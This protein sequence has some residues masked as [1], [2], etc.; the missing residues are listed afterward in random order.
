MNVWKNT[1]FHGF[2]IFRK[3]ILHSYIRNNCCVENLIRNKNIKMY[4]TIF[5]IKYLKP[6]YY[7][8]ENSSTSRTNIFFGNFKVFDDKFLWSIH[9]YSK[10]S[11]DIKY[12]LKVRNVNF[13]TTVFQQ[14]LLNVS[15]FRLYNRVEKITIKKVPINI[16]PKIFCFRDTSR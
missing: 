16:C 9:I 11:I 8:N 15:I 10:N 4:Y 5:I 2:N 1:T 3:W 14:C 12:I 13:S 7:Y 6:I